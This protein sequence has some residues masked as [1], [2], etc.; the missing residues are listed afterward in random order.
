MLTG[1]P[2]PN[3]VLDIGGELDTRPQQKMLHVGNLVGRPTYTPAFQA[4]RV[5]DG[6]W[7]S[8]D[9]H[10]PLIV[11]PQWQF[12]DE[13][14][15]CDVLPKTLHWSVRFWNLCSTNT[16]VESVLPDTIRYTEFKSTREYDTDYWCF[17]HGPSDIR[18]ATAPQAKAIR[19]GKKRKT[20]AK[21]VAGRRRKPACRGDSAARARGAALLALCDI[22]PHSSGSSSGAISQHSN[23]PESDAH[24]SEHPEDVV[25]VFDP[26]RSDDEIELEQA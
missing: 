20:N 24:G 4:L 19:T 1:T 2:P 15:V 14:E 13:Y 25:E 26:S 7:V 9:F 18:T 23:E 17:W 11:H 3:V 8:T 6:E 16:L 22:S 21:A 5:H 12:A 10:G